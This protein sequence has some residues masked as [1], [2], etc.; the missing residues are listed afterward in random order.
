MGRGVLAGLAASLLAAVATASAAMGQATSVV[1]YAHEVVPGEVIVR[2]K[3]G[4]GIES[5]RRILGTER[6]VLDRQLL[7]PGAALVNL[8]PGES[9]SSAVAALEQ[10]AGVAYAQPNYVYQ[11]DATPSD[12]FFGVLWGLQNSGQLVDDRSGTADADIDAPE[13]WNLT[14]GSDDVKV[15]VL[16]TGVDYDHPDLAGNIAALG[17]DF[18]AGDADPRDENGHG[19][20]VAGTIGANGDNGVGVT[21]INWN[22]GLIPI[23]VLSPF[24]SGTTATI[25]NGFAYAAQHGARVVNASLGGASYDPTLA[26]TISAAAGTLF[27]FAAGNGGP[28]GIGDDNDLGP[29]YYPCS[30]PSANVVC[31]AATDLNDELASF[32][33]YGPASVDLAAPGVKVGSTYVGGLYSYGDG[34]SMATP[35][36]A[37]V[38]ALMLAR[39]PGA[40]VAQLRA[41]LLGS[42]DVLGSLGNKVATSGRLNA[43]RALL[44][45]ADQPPPPLPP[46]PPP[47]S[48][49]VQ[50]LPRRAALKT[51]VVPKLTGKTVRQSRRA[52]VARSCALGKVTRTYSRKVKKGRVLR[53]SRRPSAR[54][55]RATRVNVVVSRGRGR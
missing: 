15:A 25:T 47:P 17:W 36:V 31:V 9:V 35:H 10:Q 13:A 50:P 16:D 54:L 55:P 49:V 45:I 42:V 6:A 33:N 3:P 21:G 27:V 52:L 4:L 43:Y 14:T 39:N 38:A 2:F 12:P 29:G 26:S 48:P 7:L 44:A 28:D 51:C 37:G 40:T 18:Y 19:T 24:G 30:Y 11:A 5:R 34:T 46:P 20:H 41:A 22:V 32:S 53:Q 23:R 1:P 8:A